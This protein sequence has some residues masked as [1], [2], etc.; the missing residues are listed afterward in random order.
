M[1]VIT[2]RERSA[3]RTAGRTDDD[4]AVVAA[5]AAVV[6]LTRR[7]GRDIRDGRGTTLFRMRSG[8]ES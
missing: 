2:A 4:A 7:P 1:S 5:R 3:V 6:L 8:D